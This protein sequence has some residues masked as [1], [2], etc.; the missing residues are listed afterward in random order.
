MIFCIQLRKIKQCIFNINFAELQNVV[1]LFTYRR[2]NH[3]VKIKIN[4]QL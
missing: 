1:E 4:N 3:I 2:W